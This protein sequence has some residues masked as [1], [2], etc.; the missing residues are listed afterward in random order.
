MRGEHWPDGK[1]AKTLKGEAP[2]PKK[3]WVV[4]LKAVA[5]TN[6]EASKKSHRS[7]RGVVQNKPVTRVSHHNHPSIKTHLHNPTQDNLE[8]NILNWA[9][10]ERT[11][12]PKG[13]Y[14]T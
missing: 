2:P 10:T 13:D 12:A 8:T 9:T 3:T 7:S 1:D 11:I 6:A 4:D 5:K 14:R